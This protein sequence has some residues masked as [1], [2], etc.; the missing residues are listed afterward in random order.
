M[1]LSTSF[2][3]RQVARPLVDYLRKYNSIADSVVRPELANIKLAKRR[4]GHFQGDRA[5][6]TTRGAEH[7]PRKLWQA[8]NAATNSASKQGALLGL[9]PKGR[10]KINAAPDFDRQAS[11]D[12]LTAEGRA[13][14]AAQGRG[15]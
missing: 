5:D 1:T 6:V 4:F 2:S 12:R 13:T 3:T 7:V 9:D 8:H 14:R 10:G 11:L 15:R